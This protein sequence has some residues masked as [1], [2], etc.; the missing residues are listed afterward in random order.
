[1]ADCFPLCAAGSW[2][3]A[4]PWICNGLMTAAILVFA[5]VLVVGMLE[6]ARTD[7]W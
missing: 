7:L 3:S 1:M 6:K 4:H 2:C 5:V